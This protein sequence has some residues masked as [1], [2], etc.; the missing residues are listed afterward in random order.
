MPDAEEF[1]YI[2]AIME[3]TDQEE[4]V[5]A[6]RDNRYSIRYCRLCYARKRDHPR[7]RCP[8]V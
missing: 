1:N 4:A 2:L 6:A 5:R 3:S 8:H 7:T